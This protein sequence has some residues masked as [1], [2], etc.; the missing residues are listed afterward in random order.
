MDALQE[1][2]CLEELW[3]YTKGDSRIAVAIVDGPVDR[4]HHS[5]RHASLTEIRSR[6]VGRGAASQH[7]T[8]ITSIILGQHDGLVMG[9][10][11]ECR[12]LLVPIF[13]DEETEAV[14]ACSQAELGLAI[15]EAVKAG[16]HIIN[17]SAGE[18]P[19]L[20]D[21][22]ADP[23]LYAAIENCAA[24]GTLIIAAAGNH[25]CKR[26]QLPGAFPLVLAVGALNTHGEPLTTNNW[27][28]V[29]APY[30][31]LAP[32]EAITSAVAGGGISFG[33]GTSFATAIVSG[34]AALL[35]SLQVKHGRD[36]NPRE[37]RGALLNSAIMVHAA[38]GRLMGGRLN[39]RGAISNLKCALGNALRKQ[40]YEYGAQLSP[41]TPKCCAYT[42]RPQVLEKRYGGVS[43][44]KFG[45]TDVIL[46]NGQSYSVRDLQYVTNSNHL[47]MLLLPVSNDTGESAAGEPRSVHNAVDSYL[48]RQMGLN[49]DDE[50]YA[51]LG[52]V[53]PEEHSIGL[54]SLPDTQKL[55]FGHQHL[56]A[57][58]G[59]GCTTHALPR[60]TDW[61]GEGPLNM[62]WNA[63]RYPA[64]IY[65]ISLYG[66]PQSVLN[67]NAQIVDRILSSGAKS[68]KQTENLACH[69]I[70]INTTL[71]YYRDSIRRA[72]YLEEISWLTNCAVH[73]SAV[74]NVF[75]NVPHN[76]ASFHEIFGED[77]G[78]LWLDFLQRYAEI[79]GEAFTR[80]KETFF[81]PLWKLAG[82]SAHEIRPLTLREYYS[83]QTA[84]R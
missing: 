24:S 51:L 4:T 8:Q 18:L 34:I 10:A 26:I 19:I 47:G 9:I 36:P 74:V 37:V 25:E 84:K 77:G 15:E 7:G 33:T 3:E 67:L 35:L 65:T 64:N 50:I 38:S 75:L 17:V 21:H 48:R 69:T 79:N 49:R 63:D 62:R 23:L 71:Q 73:K 81:E 57:Y 52:Y 2:L 43:A 11:P 5:L 12:G 58:V 29:H 72:E 39:V 80:A 46:P 76:E 54:F 6:P 70:D 31:L 13:T 22:A 66:V 78:A 20:P 45:T 59:N 61:K 83:F 44:E 41:K 55:Q 14:P 1:I 16:A 27:S 53:R 30:T 68:P 60:N 28:D 82:L 42:V 32:G 56:A 40:P